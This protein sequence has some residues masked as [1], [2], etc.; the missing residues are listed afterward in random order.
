MRSALAIGVLA[1]LAAAVPAEA[2]WVWSSDTGFVDTDSYET[3]DPE[4]LYKRAQELYD[5]GNY[6][7]SST[8][9]TRIALYTSDG[10]YREQALFMSGEA[11]YKAGQF[12][13]AYLAEQPQ[14][15]LACFHGLGAYGG[16]FHVI[17]E[18]LRPR[19][20]AV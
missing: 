11:Y 8:E 5:A 14:G 15:A 6:A 3:G 20:A 12:Y 13:R 2:K 4:V 17:G 19:G 10:R 9:C 16:H 7:D 18:Y 1:L